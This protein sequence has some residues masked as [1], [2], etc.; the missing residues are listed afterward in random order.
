MAAFNT[1]P[2]SDCGDIFFQDLG[3]KNTEK[4]SK[5]TSYLINGSEYKQLKRNR[6]SHKGT[7]GNLLIVGGYDGMEGAANLSGLAAL[8][9]GVG[10][11]YILNNSK[12]ILDNNLDDDLQLY[13]I[14]QIL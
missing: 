10:K 4:I 2:S 11:V 1:A 8:R 7:F 3:F 12:N 9:T 14:F 13:K 5:G 6:I